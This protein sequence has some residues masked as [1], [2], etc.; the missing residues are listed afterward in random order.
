MDTSTTPFAG[1]VSSPSDS[2]K[3]VTLE[4]FRNATQGIPLTARLVLRLALNIKAG[5]LTVVLPNRQ[6]LYFEGSESGVEATLVIH[7]YK[8]AKR[9]L[10]GGDPGFAE[11]YIRGEWSSPDITSFIRLFCSNHELVGRLSSSISPLHWA[12]RLR[13]F[14]NKNTK[15]GS[16]RNIHAHYDLGNRFYESWLDR[17]MTY[18][19]ALFTSDTEDLLSAQ[20]NK[21]A[22]LAKITGI[23]AGD[24]VLEIGCGWGGFAEHAAMNYGC[25]VKAVTISREQYEFASRRIFEAGLADRVEIALCDYRDIQ[26]QYDRIVSIEMFEAVGEEFWNSFFA[27]LNTLLHQ[28]GT[29]GMQVITIKDDIF[30]TYKQE[31]DFIRHYIFPGGM[32]PTPDIMEKLGKEAGLPLLRKQAFGTDYARTLSIWRTQFHE[33]WLD[34][35]KL[36]F[37][38]RFRRLWNYYL[39]YCEAGFL[40]GNIDVHQLVY[41][42]S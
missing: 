10:I 1:I 23:S 18:S 27:K 12:Q 25:T 24:K 16:R 39:H 35:E 15:S 36:G 19:S 37:D 40:S 5:K 38:E 4:T 20:H 31:I 11:A 7:D 8:F 14:L 33:A 42:K 29:A 28:G 9:L 30:D 41:Q 32:L 21:Y 26:G 17:S 3:R 34:I 6:T 13:H 22:N 2:F